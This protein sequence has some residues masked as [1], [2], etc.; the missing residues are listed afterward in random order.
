MTKLQLASGTLT[1]GTVWKV[2]PRIRWDGA[3]ITSVNGVLVDTLNQNSQ[4]VEITSI[5]PFTS[6]GTVTENG[7]T[8]N[9]FKGLFDATETAKILT[10]PLDSNSIVRHKTVYLSLLIEGTDADG[11]TIKPTLNSGAISVDRSPLAN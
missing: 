3:T 8:Y 11:D 6:Q 4:I 10:D 9:V 5:I 1:A 7:I 2:K